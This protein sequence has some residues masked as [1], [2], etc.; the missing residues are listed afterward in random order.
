MQFFQVVDG[1]I[2]GLHNIEDKT[3]VVINDFTYKAAMKGIL[4]ECFGDFFVKDEDVIR[5]KENYDFVSKMQNMFSYT[6][7]ILGFS[8]VKSF[9]Q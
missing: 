2:E 4:Q 9:L 1:M 7:I 5:F 6:L 3:R 8:Q